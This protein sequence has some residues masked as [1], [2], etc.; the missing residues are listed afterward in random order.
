[1]SFEIPQQ[2]RK[3]TITR[4][5]SARISS[6]DE[7]AALQAAEPYV[8]SR[9]KR[10]FRRFPN[11]HHGIRPQL[12]A[13]ITWARKLPWFAVPSDLEQLLAAEDTNAYSKISLIQAEYMRGDLRASSYNYNFQTMIWV[14]E[15]RAQ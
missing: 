12:L 8:R 13:E 2:K 3:F 15:G 4:T 5:V 10:T 7:Y 9:K 14:E 1:M 11:F 6:R